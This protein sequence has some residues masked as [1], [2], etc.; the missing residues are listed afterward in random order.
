MSPEAAREMADAG[1]LEDLPTCRVCGCDD[2]DPCPGGCAWV[3]DPE[4]AGDLCSTCLERIRLID[5][6]LEL[7]R[8]GHE[9]SPA[10]IREHL[11]ISP[12]RF[13]QLLGAVLEDELAL[14]RHPRA[15]L[16]LRGLR[17]RRRHLL[18]GAVD[19]SPATPPADPRQR[20]FDLSGPARPHREGRPKVEQLTLGG[21][22]K[23][24]GM[25]RAKDAAD[26]DWRS[27][28]EAAIA[29]LAAARNADGE[30]VEFTAED[31]RRLVGDPPDHANAMGA[32]FNTA[33]RR[34]LIVRV[35][36]RKAGRPSLHR[37]P[38]AVWRG[39]ERRAEDAA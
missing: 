32:L 2:L 11:G 23:E 33:A 14:A 39:H 19:V 7:A 35:G 25:L 1:Y 16:A 27:A 9:A 5:D 6:V 26:P 15:V 28:A 12:V 24:L 13:A 8:P 22:L 38:I 20:S 18:H 10:E 31:V 4:L 37:H 21:A 34:R 36:Y 30:L 17:D 3:P 29:A